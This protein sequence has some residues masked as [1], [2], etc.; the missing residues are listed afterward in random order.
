MKLN[1]TLLAGLLLGATILTMA[2]EEVDINVLITE[3]KNAAPA[4]RFELINKIKIQISTMNEAER[5]AALAEMQA[6]R[7]AMRATRA[8]QFSGELTEDKIAEI[9]E[10]MTPEQIEAF[11]ARMAE[12]EEYFS[13]MGP[14]S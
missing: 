6:S 12:R 2:E 8:S 3:A 9:K 14:P 10:N 13:K 11:D 1:T 7:D 5:S 4:E